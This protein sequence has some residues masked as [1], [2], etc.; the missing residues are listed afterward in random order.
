VSIEVGVFS[1]VI[2]ALEKVAKAVISIKDIPK[3]QRSRYQE[4]VRDAFTLLNSAVNLV[5]HRL[6]DILIE[7][8]RN[9]FAD[10]LRRL[11]NQ[12]E[13]WELEREVRL[14][15]KLREVHPEIDSFTLG[16]MPVRLGSKDWDNVRT[17]VDQILE[18]EG[19]MADFISLR[20]S[21][22]AQLASKAQ[23]S[24]EGYEASRRAVARARK[25]LEK[26]R[27][28][29]LSAELQFLEAIQPTR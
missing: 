17:L 23:Q 22:L 14:C 13:W 9:K 8:D 15:R 10:E 24:T 1:D 19:E 6:G 25:T 7:D 3:K 26:E 4:A 12:K 27:K 28:R 2:D 20:L 21:R 18:R 5:L 16:K 11:D 29:L